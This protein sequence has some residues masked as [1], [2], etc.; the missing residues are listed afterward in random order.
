V[1]VYSGPEITNDGLVLSLDAANLK[2]YDKYE[3]LIS[4]S[5]STSGIVLGVIGSG[6]SLP[7]GWGIDQGQ[8][9]TTL[10]VVGYGIEEGLNYIDLKFSGTTS[11]TNRWLVRPGNAVTL[12]SGV[13]YNSSVYAKTISGTPTDYRQFSVFGGGSGASLSGINSTL[14]RYSGSSAAGSTGT[15]YPR[16]DI[17]YNSIGTVMNFTI[18]VAGFQAEVGSLVTDYY[19]TT[20]TAKTRGTTWTDLTGRGSNG[21][22][23]NGPTY[24]S[25]N[26]GSL[27][28]DGVD[29][30][31]LGTINGSIFTGSF[32]QSAWIYKLNANQ[33]WQGVFTNSSPA[34]NY[35]YLMTFGN[36]SVAAP[37]NS[38][39]AN[40]V[41]I[42]DS[43]IFLDIGTHTNRWLYIVM[44]KTGSTLNIYC[45][46]DG[47][48]LQTSGTIN[49]N[50]GNFA[51]T[52]N[53]EIGRHWAGGSIVPLQ[54]NIAQ[55]Q[56]Y[57]KAL[58][59]AEIQQNYNATKGRYGL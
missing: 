19:P 3:N 39:G 21:T 23:T 48:L 35:T 27:V 30:Y 25:S 24:N 6:G 54:G 38:V 26:G 4:H 47:T 55:V 59:A 13:T 32:T 28:L 37:Y 7:T 33:I 46:K 40:Q 12:T 44:T 1:G 42:S 52:N 50:G 57:N 20:G 56:V 5:A 36:G 14:T 31:A 2:G 34:T 10:E 16:L 17:G 8:P 49:W 15:Y 53:Y 58:T 9:G 41:G 43:G 18:R 45:Y 11:T 29:D 51:T 22:L